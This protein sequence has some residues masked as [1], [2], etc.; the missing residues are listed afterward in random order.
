MERQTSYFQAQLKELDARVSSKIL[1]WDSA[2][3]SQISGWVTAF[4]KLT[5]PWIASQVDLTAQ[6]E[7]L[8][9]KVELLEAR[10][11]ELEENY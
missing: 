7:S 10:L 5:S 3:N 9:N 1:I 8:T 2:L 4:Q 11:A 6:V